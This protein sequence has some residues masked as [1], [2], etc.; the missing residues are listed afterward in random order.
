M[1]N[2]R[3]VLPNLWRRFL[4]C[5]SDLEEALRRV[6]DA[7]NASMPRIVTVPTEAED[8]AKSGEAIIL[9]YRDEYFEVKSSAQSELAADD[10]WASRKAAQI[11]RVWRRCAKK[12]SPP[13]AAAEPLTEAQASSEAAEA[14]EAAADPPQA[15]AVIADAVEKSDGYPA[16]LSAAAAVAPVIPV[17]VSLESVEGAS[18]MEE[19][20]SVQSV[21]TWTSQM[22]RL[23]SVASVPSAGDGGPSRWD[24]FLLDADH[25]LD[26]F[27]RS[28]PEVE[29]SFKQ[30]FEAV[31]TDGRALMKEII[32]PMT[33]YLRKKHKKLPEGSLF[34]LFQSL[35]EDELL[36]LVSYTYDLR[37]KY[38]KADG[39]LNFATQ[40]S[41]AVLNETEDPHMNVC[42]HHFKTAVEKCRSAQPRT[43]YCGSD[44]ASHGSVAQRLTMAHFPFARGLAMLLCKR[45]RLLSQ[46]A[47]WQRLCKPNPSRKWMTGTA[48]YRISTPQL[49][50]IYIHVL[51]KILVIS[52]PGPEPG[53]VNERAKIYEPCQLCKDCTPQR[54]LWQHQ[55]RPT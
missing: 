31:I 47:S 44:S 12:A 39:K 49:L 28:V 40:V 52:D 2:A 29:G 16:V 38:P 18:E 9:K 11:Q 20:R 30:S 1:A 13:A 7:A 24:R 50:C 42:V 15:T 37:K 22:S 55:S 19:V 17:E 36:A 53:E 27:P 51:V 10:Q 23:A 46:S 48:M 32:I 35:T 4:D 43:L 8:A 6:V 54:H 21:L 14:A 34:Q 41:V 26:L 5:G 25:F 33:Q 3:C 45:L